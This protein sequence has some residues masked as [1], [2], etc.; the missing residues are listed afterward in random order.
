MKTLFAFVAVVSLLCLA[1]VRLGSPSSPGDG[2]PL[3]LYCAAGIRLAVE[4]AVRAFEQE[5]GAIV[6]IQ[7]GGS[8]SLLGQLQVDGDAA[9]LYLPGDEGYLDAARDQGLIAEILPLASMRPVLAVAHGNP[10]QIDSMEEVLEKDLPFALG[11]PAAAAVGRVVRK[12]Y[13]ERGQWQEIEGKAKVFQPTVTELATSLAIGQVDAAIVWD[14]TVTQ[15]DGLDLVRLPE[16]EAVPVRVAVGVLTMSPRAASALQLARYL[17]A[18]D[19]GQAHFLAAGL[20]PVEGDTW[21]ARPEVLVYAG[22]M[23]HSALEETLTTWARREGV[24]LI[25][26]Y[27]GCGILVAQMRAGGEPDAFFA[28]DSSFMDDVQQRFDSRVLLS[29]NPLVMIT[30]PGNPLQLK[31]LGDLARPGLRVGLAHPEHSALGRLT[32]QQMEQENLA[33]DFASSGNLKQDAPQGDFL[34][35][36]L[37]T[38]ALDATVVYIS[39]AALA[40]AKIDRVPLAPTALAE[41]PFAMAR[42]SDQRYL[43]QRLFDAVTSSGSQDRFAELGFDWR[44]GEDSQ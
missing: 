43:L 16:L 30:A 12:V 19:R 31:G 44:F 7:Y 28:C 9:D 26:V 25:R 4:P 8:G 11:S 33:A 29:N 15:F 23:F 18:H 32:R 3:T 10:H 24:E 40:G 14:A 36:A 17:Q 42:Q 2:E 22:S 41:Q 20:T 34:V 35:N 37:L 5:T 39:N 38:G 27:N 21:A 13:S 6:H 1:L